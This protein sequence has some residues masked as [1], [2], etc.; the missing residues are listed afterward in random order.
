MSGGSLPE[1]LVVIARW[2][3]E[4]ATTITLQDFTIGGESVI[5][6]FSSEDAF[7]AQSAGSGFEQQGAVIQR[8]FLHAMLRGDEVLM[9]DPGSAAPRRLR[10][11][12]LADPSSGAA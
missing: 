9:L 7:R 3:D 1:E 5:P 2:R 8:A 11:D 6:L 10:P 12:D 4:Q